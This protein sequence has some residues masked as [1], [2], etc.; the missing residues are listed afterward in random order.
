MIAQNR[1]P[2]R[3]TAKTPRVAIDLVDPRLIQAQ[4]AFIFGKITYGILNNRHK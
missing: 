2:T 3:S 4:M 1:G